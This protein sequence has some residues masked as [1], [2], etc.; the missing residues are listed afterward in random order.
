VILRRIGLLDAQSRTT[1]RATQLAVT[2]L[3]I[4][5]LKKQDGYE[6][7]EFVHELGVEL[8]KD[9]ALLAECPEGDPEQLNWLKRQI[10]NLV[11]RAFR[12]GHSD[13]MDLEA[14]ERIESL[15]E[16]TITPEQILSGLQLAER[17]DSIVMRH[18]EFAPVIE[19]AELRKCLPKLAAKLG[20]NLHDLRRLLR[21][22]KDHFDRHVRDDGDIPSR[23]NEIDD[24]K[25]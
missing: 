21:R 7:Q 24:G 19:H 8:F 10:S 17:L 4:L 6:G 20:M 25:P 11:Q 15:A 13:R 12:A 14:S 2:A 1:L 23:A 5:R 18:P 16:D 3:R 22:F 9:D